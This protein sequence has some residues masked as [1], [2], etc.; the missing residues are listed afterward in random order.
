MYV[1]VPMGI[2]IT[3]RMTAGHLL[4]ATG[5]TL[6]VVIGKGYEERDSERKFG[7]RYRQRVSRTTL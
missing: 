1:G 6:Y 5:L 3:P 2:W 7:A 4:L